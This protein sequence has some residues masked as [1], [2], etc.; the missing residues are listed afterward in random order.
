MAWPWKFQLETS[1]EFNIILTCE[2]RVY[3]A[4]VEHFA[5]NDSGLV[6][7]SLTF[8]LAS[9]QLAVSLNKRSNTWQLLQSSVLFSVD[10]F[11]LS[12]QK[13]CALWRFE[14]YRS[15]KIPS[16]HREE[17]RKITNICALPLLLFFGWIPCTAWL[18]EFFS[19]IIW[20]D[21]SFYSL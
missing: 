21:T 20:Q 6:N 9:T 8:L 13:Q 17:R 14:G 5:N 7:N 12:Y 19:S 2:E 18:D 15:S 11:F 10:P 3:D 1:K 16:R 4:V